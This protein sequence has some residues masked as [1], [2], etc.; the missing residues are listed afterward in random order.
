M[1]A[2]FHACEHKIFCVLF[3]RFSVFCVSQIALYTVSL[4]NHTV[5]KVSGLVSLV[6]DIPAE[7]GKENH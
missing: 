6:S 7:D 2:T 1:L 4:S 3:V 5:K